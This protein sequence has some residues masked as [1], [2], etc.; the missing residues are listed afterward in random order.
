MTWRRLGPSHVTAEAALA[1]G[2]EL[3]ESAKPDDP[4]TMIWWQVAPDAL[5]LG[6]G[7]KVAPDE[8]A[9]RSAGVSIV[10]RSSGGG[11]VLW[12]GDLLGLDVIVPRSHNLYSDDVVASYR[13]LGEALAG[14]IAALGAP[15]R[16]LSPVEARRDPGELGDLACFASHSPWEVLAG[17]R[18]VVGLSQVRRRAGALLQAGILLRHQPDRLPRLLALDPAA[19]AATVAA[20]AARAV[21]LDALTGATA[22]EVIATVEAALADAAPD[23]RVE[24][25]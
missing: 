7:S 21:A 5:V 9:C 22:A 20:L 12:D 16:A 24:R 4:P 8:V 17:E 23:L 3:L 25:H 18:K 11:P 15:A 2:V 1:R 14:A 19:R 6:R 10:R 13:W